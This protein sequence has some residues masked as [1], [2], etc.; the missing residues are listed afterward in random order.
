[1]RRSVSLTV[2]GLSYAAINAVGG[3][4]AGALTALSG[5]TWVSGTGLRFIEQ[6]TDEGEPGG[7][8]LIALVG[9]LIVAVLIDLALVTIP[10]QALRGDLAR[11][12]RGVRSVLFAVG[13]AVFLGV[14]FSTFVWHW[15]L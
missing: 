1:M 6:P 15:M 7:I 2:W 13:M 9:I 4:L 12:R 5:L 8:V 11:D 10:L 3:W 14:G